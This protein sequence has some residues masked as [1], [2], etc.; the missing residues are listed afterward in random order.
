MNCPKSCHAR[1]RSLRRLTAAAVCALLSQAAL[2]ACT[3]S[4]TAVSFGGYDVFAA[5]PNNNGVGSMNIVCTKGKSPPFAVR[6]STGQ[7]NSYA[8]RLMN[9]GAD[10]MNYNLYTSAARTVVWGD[11]TGGSSVMTAAERSTTA[12]SIFGQIPA[13]QDAA[14]GAYSDSITAMVTF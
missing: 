12:L 14:V 3:I 10:S 5:T 7:S 11:G 6:L 2:A 13:G 9:S 8:S 4:A 1:R